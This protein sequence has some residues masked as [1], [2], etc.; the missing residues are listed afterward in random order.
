M[1]LARPPLWAVSGWMANDW[2]RP[3]PLN[4]MIPVGRRDV[5]TWGRCLASV[6]LTEHF[7]C[8]AGLTPG[9]APSPVTGESLGPRSR[10]SAHAPSAALELLRVAIPAPPPL[11][12]HV[13]CDGLPVGCFAEHEQRG[14][15]PLL[16]QAPPEV[17]AM[18]ACRL[19]DRMAMAREQDAAAEADFTPQ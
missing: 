11:Q 4:L 1:T 7:I 8:R 5:G 19:L 2:M 17:L 13:T 16:P 3:P 15:Q 9:I 12:R 18:M 14:A 10:R 6:R